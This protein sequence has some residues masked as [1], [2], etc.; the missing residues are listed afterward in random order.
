MAA[1]SIGNHRRRSLSL[2][3][4][5]RHEKCNIKPK[6]LASIWP[7][8]GKCRQS[9]SENQSPLKFCE[10]EAKCVSPSRGEIV[11]ATD[12]MYF[13][14]AMI[15]SFSNAHLGNE[16]PRCCGAYSKRISRQAPYAVLAGTASD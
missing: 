14:G 7:V 1:K 9:A 6:S 8:N 4:L 5:R 3:A 11:G 16:R 13:R 2:V 10:Y 15:S 12:E